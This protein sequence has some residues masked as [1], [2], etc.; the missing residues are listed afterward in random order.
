MTDYRG[1]VLTVVRCVPY[2]KVISYG[3]VAAYIGAAKDA[4]EIGWALSSMGQVDNFPWWRVINNAGRLSIKGNPEATADKQKQ[5]LEKE[6]IKISAEHTLDIEAYRFRAD[7]VMLVHF[8]LE[9]A[10]IKD[11]LAKFEEPK[12]ISL[13]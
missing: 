10:A 2:G 7:E 11:V 8:G 9:P 12:Q 3:Q 6:G 4:R 5:L 1:P 13:F